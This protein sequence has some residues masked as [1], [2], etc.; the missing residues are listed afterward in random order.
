MTFGAHAAAA[1]AAIR[2]CL[3]VAASLSVL[4][5]AGCALRTAKALV[6]LGALHLVCSAVARRADTSAL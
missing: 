1:T 3:G 2:V 6:V 5:A 4:R